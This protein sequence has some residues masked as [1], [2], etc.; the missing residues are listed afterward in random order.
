MKWFLTGSM[1]DLDTRLRE[2]GETVVSNESMYADHDSYE[3]MDDYKLRNHIA[4]VEDFD[5]LVLSQMHRKPF[6][7]KKAALLWV[8]RAPSGTRR[9]LIGGNEGDPIS[10]MSNSR[11]MPMCSVKINSLE[12]YITDYFG[13]KSRSYSSSIARTYDA[14][15]SVEFL[16]EAASDASLQRPRGR[17]RIYGKN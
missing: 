17:G 16:I 14:R 12:V 1:F 6:Y 7:A 2:A 13:D 15:K 9:V 3:E 11:K 8:Q 4:Q 10:V 5:V